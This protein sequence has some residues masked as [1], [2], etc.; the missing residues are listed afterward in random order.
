[1]AERATDRDGKKAEKVTSKDHVPVW[2]LRESPQACAQLDALANNH[3]FE[4]V[5][6]AVRWLIIRNPLEAGQLVPGKEQTFV[7]KTNDFLAIGLPVILITYSIIDP[8]A[9]IF[10]IVSII[11]V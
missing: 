8:T 7:L 9:R 4:E 5:W 1:M 11:K 10:E 2:N 6:T 3:R